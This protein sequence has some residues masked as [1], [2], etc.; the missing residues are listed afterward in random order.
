VNPSNSCRVEAKRV[1]PPIVERL[2]DEDALKRSDHSTPTVFVVDDDVPVRKSLELLIRCT[3]WMPEVFASVP[4]FLSRPPVSAPSCLVLD[5]SQSDLNGLD[6]QKRIAEDRIDMP[7]ICITGRGDVPMAVEAMK[8]GAV[9][10]LTKPFRDEVV[11][12][13]IRHA[14]ELS[15]TALKQGAKI[16]VIRDSYG[17]LT[18]RERQV[19]E[20]VVRGWLNKHVGREL[21][22]SEITVKAHRG[23][24]MQKMN[25]AS[26]ADLV[27]MAVTLPRITEALEF[28]V[29]QEHCVRWHRTVARPLCEG[30]SVST[31]YPVSALE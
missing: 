21:G 5:I 10:C 28:L 9:E 29:T 25:A 2:R 12:G 16:R 6:L 24:M 7:I 27:K 11:L 26:L 1:C 18:R 3:G 30:S 31:D 20:L 4:A 13:A 15:R 8:A 22:I 14:I 19:M 23:R 17:S